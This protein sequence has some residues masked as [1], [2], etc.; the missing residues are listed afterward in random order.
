MLFERTIEFETPAFVWATLQTF[1]VTGDIF[2]V[3]VRK[4]LSFLIVICTLLI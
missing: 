2:F 3:D 1:D 4:F